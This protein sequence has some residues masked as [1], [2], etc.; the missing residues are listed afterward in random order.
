MEEDLFE[1]PYK[2]SNNSIN[3]NIKINNPID[4]I[5]SNIRIR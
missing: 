4:S 2:T 1:L 5:N 3:S